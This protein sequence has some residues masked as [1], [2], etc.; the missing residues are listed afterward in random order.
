M[1]KRILVASIVAIVLMTA[2]FGFLYPVADDR[3]RL[4]SRSR[5]RP[6]AA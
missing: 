5:A 6:A 1:L 2:F 3:L 4:R